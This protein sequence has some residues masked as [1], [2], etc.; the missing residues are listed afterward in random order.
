MGGGMPYY[1]PPPPSYDAAMQGP[2]QIYPPNPS[3]YQQ[4]P[5]PG[6]PQA[7]PQ[8]QYYPPQMPPKEQG[9]G[10]PPY[11]P[12]GQFGGPGTSAYPQQPQQPTMPNP[13][14]FGPVAP[15]TAVFDAGARYNA[16]GSITVPPPP[17]GYMPTAAQAAAMSG[18][19]VHVQKEK[20]GFF[21]G[22]KGAG[23]TFW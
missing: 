14:Y 10:L 17:P 23:F 6:Y 5:Y 20:N 4:P 3:M 16:N 22:G 21:S 19:S 13:G 8:P 7:M 12:Q 9:H 15:V 1:P 11:P 18:Q 2:P